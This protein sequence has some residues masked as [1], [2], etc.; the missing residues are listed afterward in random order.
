MMFYSGNPTMPL[1]YGL[2]GN[3]KCP[4]TLYFPHEIT[5]EI[6]MCRNRIA[7]LKRLGCKF[8]GRKT[9]I[10]WV[11]AFLSQTAEEQVLHRPL[12]RQHSI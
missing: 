7:N 2:L 5:Q 11:R 10:N 6:G 4:D 3:K 8:H 12:N 1:Y 9:T